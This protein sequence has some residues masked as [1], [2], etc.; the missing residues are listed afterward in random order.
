[1]NA[2]LDFSHLFGSNCCAHT[3]TELLLLARLL[4]AARKECRALANGGPAGSLTM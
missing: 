3:C 2:R 1:M 4:G